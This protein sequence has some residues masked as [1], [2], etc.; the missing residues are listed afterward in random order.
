MAAISM[1]LGLLASCRRTRFP[2][3]LCSGLSLFL[4]LWRQVAGR[5]RCGPI[6]A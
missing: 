6:R 3:M 2:I 5:M 4:H 1:V